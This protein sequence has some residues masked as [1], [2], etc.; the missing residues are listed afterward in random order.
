MLDAGAVR[1]KYG[2]VPALIPDYLAVVGD[3]ADGYPG[4]ITGIGAVSTARM[5][6]RYGT[7]EA[8]P[9]D[10]LSDQRKRALLF[11]KLATLKTDVKLFRNVSTSCAGAG[12]PMPSRRGP[13]AWRCRACSGAALRRECLNW[14]IPMS[15]AHLRTILREWT[16][17]YN[18][19]RPHSA[20]GP[21]VPD[22]P[23]ELVE[24]PEV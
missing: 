9:A 13:S 3:A 4:G 2:A 8:F 19:G 17:H 12:P 15:E 23:T 24:A 16:T 14:L 1:P 10:V 6:N 5:L 21:G 7:I 11:K 18:Q 22:P 20:L